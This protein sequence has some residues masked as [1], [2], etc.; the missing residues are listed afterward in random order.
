MKKYIVALLALGNM[1]GGHSQLKSPASFLGYEPG[2][3]FS[4]HHQVVDYFQHVAEVSPQ[5]VLQQYGES[6][7]KRPLYLAFV[8]T[9]ENL[10]KLETIRT[11]N[12]KRAGL[13]SG[14]PELSISVVWLSY[15]VHGNESVSTE[16]ALTTLYELVRSDSDKAE[17]LENT[18]IVMDPCVNPDG[19]ERYVN[20]YWQYANQPYNAN[21]DSWEHHESWP[22]GRA[23]HYLFDLNRDWAWQTQVESQQRMAVYN[24]WLPQIHVDFHE[25][26]INEPYYFAPAAEPFHELITDWQRDFQTQIGKNHS[27]YFD[28]NN[29][30]YF[31]KQYFDLLYPSYGDTYPIYNGA[32]GM[33]YEQGGSG[34][35]GLGVIKEEGDTLT[36]KDRIAHHYTTGLSTIEITSQNNEKVLSEFTKFFKQK[37]PSDYKSYVLKYDGNQGKFDALK[38][39]LDMQ[40][41][42][43]GAASVSKPLSG[44][45]YGSGKTK[46]FSI[47]S[48]DIVISTDQPKSVLTSVLFE[49]KTKLSDSLTYDITAW[50][51]PYAY[52]VEAYAT[53][54][55][56]SVGASKTTSSELT[57]LSPAYGYIFK[58]ENMQDAR[59]LTAMLKE[60]VQVRFT[61]QPI[62]LEDKVFNQGSFLVT[63]RDNAK[64]RDFTNFVS[65]LS[66]QYG[67]QATPIAS[68]FVSAGPDIGSADVR[69]L[70]APEVALIGGP[71]TS[72]LDFGATWHFFEQELG[73]PVTTLSTEYFDRVD[74]SQYDVLIMQNGWYSD[75]GANTMKKISD[76]VADGGTLIAVQ[77][78]LN[79]LADSDYSGLS[80]FNSEAE[81]GAFEDKDDL[82]KEELKLVPHADR[83][84]YDIREYVAGAVFKV[85]LDKTH[86]LAFGYGD[87]YFSLK[88]SASRY[89][90]LSSGNVGVIKSPEDHLSGFAGQL[91][92]SRVGSSLVF[93][94]ESIGAGHMI[95][96]ADNP[97]FRSFW[98]NGKLLFT[99]AIFY[100]GN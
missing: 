59:L 41:I 1:L 12:L 85:H 97:L 4:R 27:K 40:G 28:A 3:Q 5:V 84:R 47:V 16:A 42:R 55:V 15:N 44:Y 25:Q 38:R 32:I 96:M 65:N 19:R 17:W 61:T 45:H 89:G 30:F 82:V 62:Q 13:V 51:V 37:G 66:T 72:S 46:S 67:R 23:N 98:Q 10:D 79:K 77:G 9:K 73:Y 88:T 39:W 21:P 58:W 71:G 86:P 20:F 57:Q 50:A 91:V 81:K 35:A 49:P 31:T 26:G 69:F 11:D 52:G 74:L 22:G 29:W 83:E 68:G 34:R 92:R 14:S 6:Y 36:L 94:V 99:N 48:E 2:E 64:I 43:Y 95:Y 100:V 56:L 93:G 24:Q 54:A 60:K 7:E 80:A 75:F 87:S 33:T 78:A 8:S 90:Y 70:R 18:L 76:W 53:S 63:Q